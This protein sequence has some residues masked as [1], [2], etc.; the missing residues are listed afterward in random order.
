[1]ISCGFIGIGLIGGSIA[2]A[3][4]QNRTDIRIIACDPNEDTCRLAI[5]E[6]IADAVYPE[7]QDAFTECD[8]I[9]LC[10]PVSRND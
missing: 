9:F 8:Y 1:M 7:P 2:R 10:P 4:R 6:G 3:L 5:E